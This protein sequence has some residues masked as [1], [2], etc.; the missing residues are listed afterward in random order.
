M[1]LTGPGLFF[2]ALTPS[3]CLIPHDRFKQDEKW[4]VQKAM[5]QAGRLAVVL[6]FLASVALC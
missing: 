5:K 1:S 2:K 3:R 6:A 4:K